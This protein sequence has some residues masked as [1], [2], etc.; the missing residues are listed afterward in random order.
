MTRRAIR[1]LPGTVGLLL[2]TLELSA[3]DS[4]LVTLGR[5][6]SG[7]VPS[8]GTDTGGTNTGGTDTGGTDTG[9]TATGGMTGAGA[10]GGAT[11]G[12]ATDGGA[13]DTGGTDGG[14]TDTGGTSTGGQMFPLRFGAMRQL[15]ELGSPNKDD[16]ATLTRDSLV[17]Y[18]TSTRGENADVYRAARRSLDEPFDEP[19]LFDPVL[20][21]GNTSSPAISLDGR[22]L[23]VGQE[24]EGGIGEIDIWVT[25]FDGV[26]WSPLRNVAGLNSPEKDIPRPPAGGGVVMPLGSQRG[27]PDLDYRTFLAFRA[28]ETAAFGV[29]QAIPELDLG[30]RVVDGFLTEDLLMLFFSSGESED[31]G[32]LF[33]ARRASPNDPFGPPEPLDALNT[34]YDERDPWISPDLTRFFF[35]SNRNLDHEIFEVTVT[36]Q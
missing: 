26:E 17:V 10:E 31:D 19:V 21:D 6:P 11:D 28:N 16:N 1:A 7:M 35:T 9:G 32:D 25:T 12:G 34:S 13:T 2:A 4:E 30:Q 20:Y 14:A 23:W 18:F 27:G 22:T 3:C 33:V 36:R 15:T 5:I 8:S 29:P 24:R